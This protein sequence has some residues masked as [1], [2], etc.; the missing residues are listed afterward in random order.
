[1]VTVGWALSWA[2]VLSWPV[3]TLTYFFL[4]HTL[5]TS[6]CPYAV[7]LLMVEKFYFVITSQ[8]KWEN[9]DR[10]RGPLVSTWP[11]SLTNI[12]PDGVLATVCVHVCV[13]RVCVLEIAS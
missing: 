3:S 6:C 10:Q 12:A 13:Q 9:E 11:V 5:A 8:Q 4:Q 1:M 7:S 2:D